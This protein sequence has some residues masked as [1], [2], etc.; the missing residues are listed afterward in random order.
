MILKFLATPLNIFR[1][2]LIDGSLHI[3]VVLK[4]DLVTLERLISQGELHVSA[5]A[6]AFELLIHLDKSVIPRNR[7]TKHCL[8]KQ[9][10]GVS[11]FN[12][13]GL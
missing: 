2:Y 6:C 7:L 3:R 1:V 12:I 9:L 4:S 10:D 8:L 13:L 11:L 5:P